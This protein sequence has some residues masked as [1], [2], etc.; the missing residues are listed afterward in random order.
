MKNV[1]T[2]ANAM[3][4]LFIA[5]NSSSDNSKEATPTKTKTMDT[6]TKPEKNNAVTE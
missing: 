5:C 2:Y 4:F 6:T 3:T 1:M